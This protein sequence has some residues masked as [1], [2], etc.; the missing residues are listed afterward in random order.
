MALIYHVD[1]H[2][3]GFA[4]RVA[5]VWSETFPSHEEALQ[6]ARAAAKRQRLTGE[7]AEITFQDENGAWL[8]QEVSGEER[9]ETGVVDDT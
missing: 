6:A 2:D 7:G 5:E 9:P 1:E 8:T 3:E 4:Y